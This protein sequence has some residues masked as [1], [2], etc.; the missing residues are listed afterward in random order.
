MRVRQFLQVWSCRMSAVGI[1]CIAGQLWAMPV[2]QYVA[3]FSF[4]NEQMG[5]RDALSFEIAAPRNDVSVRLLPG[6]KL[7][8]PITLD[9]L[10]NRT[11]VRIAGTV[12]AV[13]NGDTA[14]IE[15]RLKNG[16]KEARIS[17][18]R[19]GVLQNGAVPVP[20]PPLGRPKIA[21]GKWELDPQF[22]VFNDIAD[23]SFGVRNLQLFTNVTPDVFEALDPETFLST[24]FDPS[25]PNFFV[26]SGTNTDDLGLSFTI[27]PEPDPGLFLVAI[28]QIVDEAGN[29]VG[30]FIHGVQA[31]AVSEPCTVALLL[32]LLWLAGGRAMWHRAFS[33]SRNN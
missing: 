17:D 22:T 25:L 28:G 19:W 33:P 1:L 29:V 16:R 13:N 20:L 18:A 14:E 4:K 32:I 10:T 24:T 26:S 27:F 8:G 5:Q 11:R 9:D 31:Q 23:V 30:A 2:N 3:K 12:R 6:S 7:N 15:I 21:G